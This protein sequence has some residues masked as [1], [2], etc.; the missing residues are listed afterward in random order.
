MNNEHDDD[1]QPLLVLYQSIP[2]EEPPPE[3]DVC[4]MQAA[5]QAIKVSIP[6]VVN[7]HRKPSAKPWIKPLSY[8][9]VMVLCLGVVLRIQMELPEIVQSQW[10]IFNPPS[11]SAESR[12]EYPLQ[13]LQQAD[14]DAPVRSLAP[15]AEMMP[16]KPAPV[17][18]LSKQVVRP[19]SPAPT[20]LS[21][22][23]IAK[24]K[25]EMDTMSSEAPVLPAVAS[26]APPS[27][28][29]AERLYAQF[30]KGLAAEYFELLIPRIGNQDQVR[31][32]LHSHSHSYTS[33]SIRMYLFYF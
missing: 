28:A 3:L 30:E 7:L 13:E 27:A 25:T 16:E 20:A 24:S 33:F 14:R 32:F 1:N 9:A 8:A 19:S 22:Q 17:S 23:K 21:E 4:I 12:A 31:L 18:E 26:D 15:A 11:E 5:H 2:K 29:V 10:D 6:R